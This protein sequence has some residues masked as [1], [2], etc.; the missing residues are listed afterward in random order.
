MTTSFQSGA[1]S[2]L[3]TGCALPGLPVTSAQLLQRI[4][5]NFGIAP[6]T[7]AAL[8]RRLGIETRHIA[9][10]LSERLEAP[11]SGARNPDLCAD[12]LTQALHSADMSP[13]ALQYLIGHTATP[14]RLIPPNISEVATKIKFSMALLQNYA[15]LAPALLT[16]CN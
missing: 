9:R 1:L 11:M 7:G 10:A 3:G 13:P 12:A 8:A 2:I 6:D 16:R 4:A 15:R 5:S 14:A